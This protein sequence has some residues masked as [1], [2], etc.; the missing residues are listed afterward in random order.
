MR[1][2]FFATLL[3]LSTLYA[4]QPLLPVLA[5]EFGVSR[6]AIALLTTLTFI[7]LAL[8]PLGYGYLLE[9]VEPRRVLRVCFLLLGL[10]AFVFAVSGSYALLLAVR[11]FQG[12]LVPALLTSLMTYVSRR[13]QSG[14]VQ[15]T[16]A[17]YI[18]ATILGGFLGRLCSGAIAGWLHWRASFWLLG[19]SL[20]LC[21]VL[22]GRLPPAGGLALTRPRA[23]LVLDVLRNGFF[24][25]I[26]LAVFCLFLAFAAVMN[27]IP[28]RLTDISRHADEFRIGLMYSGYLMG[29]VTSLSA[30]RLARR[31]GGELPALLVGFSVYCVA[32]LLLSVPRV[33]VLFADMFL[34]CG[35]MFLVHAT[36]SGWLNRF[37]GSH[38]GMVNGLYIAFYYGGGAL[39][40]SA[41]G[42][43][44]SRF[45][46]NGVIVMLAV[47]ALVGLL[48]TLSCRRF[49]RQGLSPVGGS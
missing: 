4:P 37:A 10:S 24:L 27:F 28:F 36:A 35:A 31:F 25:R 26:Y 13:S 8:A 46:W 49:L 9:A 41:P 2:I 17:A 20:L 16:M 32:I 48:L 40:S 3:T 11:L 18:A 6:D 29:V 1:L 5:A 47:F 30:V 22:L 42:P 23:R 38:K 33:A 45:G 34:F 15:R 43:V 39:G 12:M 21:A 19:A 44:Y 14:E 7:P